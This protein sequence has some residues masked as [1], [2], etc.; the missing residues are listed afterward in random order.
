MNPVYVKGILSKEECKK[1]TN[2]MT[3]LIEAGHT[4]EDTFS[5]NNIYKDPLFQTLLDR[6]KGF[7]SKVVEKELLPTYSYSRIYSKGDGLEPH[8]DRP[9]CEISL[10]LQV[11]SDDH[12]WPIYTC[13]RESHH[14]T[15]GSVDPET[16]NLDNATAHVLKDGDALIYAGCDHIHWRDVYQGERHHQIFLHF[17]DKNGPYSSFSGDK[18]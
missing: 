8:V 13:K 2:Y 5:K 17:V 16:I 6:V 14:P 3:K 18:R 9:S 15:G 4:N 1:F 10:T 12:D 7:A 11:S